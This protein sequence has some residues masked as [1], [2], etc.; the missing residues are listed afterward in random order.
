MLFDLYAYMYLDGGYG[1]NFYFGGRF[2]L[3]LEQTVDSAKI[4]INLIPILLLILLKKKTDFFDN[5]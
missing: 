4:G 5:L 2:E 1:F 3:G